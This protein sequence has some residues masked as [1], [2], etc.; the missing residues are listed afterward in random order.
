MHHLQLWST[1]SGG[2]SGGRGEQPGGGSGGI[3]PSQQRALAR[4]RGEGAHGGSR[5]EGP[6]R[7]PAPHLRN[8]VLVACHSVYTGL[9][10]RHSEEKSSWFLLDYQKV[11]ALGRPAA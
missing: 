10:F 11:G 1:V 6:R 5:A 3:T 9:D 8:L 4:A 2:A 7:F